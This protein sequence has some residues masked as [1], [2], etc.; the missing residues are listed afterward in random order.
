M[1]MVIYFLC[2]ILPT[3]ATRWRPNCS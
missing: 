2:T 1:Y 3:N